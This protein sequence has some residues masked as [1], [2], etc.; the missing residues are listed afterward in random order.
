MTDNRI[1]NA[2]ESS[3]VDEIAWQEINT[4]ERLLPLHMRLRE[5]L[6]ALGRID[7][8]ACLEIGAV[9]G[10]LSQQL[11]RRGGKWHSVVYDGASAQRIASVIEENVVVLDKRLPFEKKLFDVI[12]VNSGL[13]RYRDDISFIEDCHRVLKPD[14]RIV[15][16]V[17][18][19]KRFTILRS[20]RSLFGVSPELR[21]YVRSGYS[22]QH[23][24]EVLKNGFDVLNMK[25]YSRFFTELVDVFVDRLANGRSAA[26]LG[27]YSRRVYSVGGFFY[28]IADQFDMLLLFNRGHRLIAIGKR[29]GWRPRDAPIL[30]DGRSISE[31]VLSKAIQ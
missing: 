31:A 5:I 24:F 18:R 17:S 13:E 25:S 27:G 28:R 6:R 20:L 26:P 10:A 11:R 7:D 4:F 29:R 9:N 16:N 21:G 19:V 12:L 8:L 30:V 23:L 22:E 14:G 2:Q 1:V 3:A 15:V